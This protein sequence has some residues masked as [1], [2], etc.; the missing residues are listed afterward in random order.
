MR[1][2]ELLKYVVSEIPA[3]A[4]RLSR[5]DSKTAWSR[6]TKEVLCELGRN[7]GFSPYASAHSGGKR[8]HEFL[9]DVV[10][11]SELN[12]GIR[13]AVESE[14]G[15]PEAVLYDFEKLMCIKS[16]LKLLLV[17]QGRPRMVERLER[18][19]ETKIPLTLKY[20]T[21]KA[22]STEGKEKLNKVKPRSIAQASRVSG[23]TPSDISI[24]LVYLK[25]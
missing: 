2:K 23:V 17:E 12:G 3:A 25:N 4:A 20:L 7:K 6:A 1:P 21:L 22:L 15:G 14:L 13:L 11:Y 10:W 18:Y 8:L 24:L 9:L 5:K 19:E 16:P